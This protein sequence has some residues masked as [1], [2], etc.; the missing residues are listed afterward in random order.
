[1]LATERFR[2]QHQ[3]LLVLASEITKLL[4]PTKLAQ[5]ATEVRRLVAKFRGLLV[6]HARM[7]NEALYPRLLEHADS[8]IREK[9]GAIFKDVGPIYDAVDGYSERWPNAE[10]IQ[11]DAPGF[12]KDTKHIMRTL[13]ARVT[14]ENDELYPLADSLG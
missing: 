13:G 6:V 10:A 7:E 4:D 2:R 1:M 11:S 9:V 12:I 14:R 8:A 5:D 3:E